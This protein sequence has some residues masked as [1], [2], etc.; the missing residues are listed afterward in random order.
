MKDQDCP[1]SRILPAVNPGLRRLWKRLVSPVRYQTLA[2]ALC[3]TVPE[4][5]PKCA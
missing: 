4:R 2:I 1:Y 3:V 5:S